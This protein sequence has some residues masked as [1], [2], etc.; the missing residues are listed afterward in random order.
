MRD[1]NLRTERL[2][3]PAGGVYRADFRNLPLSFCELKILSSFRK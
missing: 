1:I 3:L 2:I